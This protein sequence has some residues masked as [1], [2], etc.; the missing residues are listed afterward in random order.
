[1]LQWLDTE[2][3]ARR[4]FCIISTIYWWSISPLSWDCGKRRGTCPRPIGGKHTNKIPINLPLFKLDYWKLESESSLLYTE[5]EYKRLPKVKH[6][7]RITFE[8]LSEE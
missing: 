1:M 6:P 4:Y 2:N 8:E 7:E 5:T 3:T